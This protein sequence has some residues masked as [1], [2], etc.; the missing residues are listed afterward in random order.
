MKA[1]AVQRRRPQ[2]GQGGFVLR[3]ASSPCAG[4]G[5]SRETRVQLHQ[6]PVAVHLGQHAG[7]G[8]G[9]AGGVALD[10]G[11]LRAVPVDGVAAVDEQEVGAERQLLDGAAHGQQRGLADVDAVDGLRIDRRNGPGNG[12]GANLHG[13]ARCAFSRRAFLSRS[14]LAGGSRGRITAAATTGP[15]SG[16]R[17][18]SSSPAMR[19]APRLRA[20]S[21]SVHPQRIAFAM[22]E[23]RKQNPQPHGPG[24]LK[25]RGVGR[26]R[27]EPCR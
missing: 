9:E 6:Q 23:Y 12:V 15:N 19:S 8:N 11:L 14:G 17:P 20:A 5:R 13:R 24:V 4:P 1:L 18:T 3:R 16:P 7:G 21:S 26:A 10:D 27:R 22:L 25:K 2:A